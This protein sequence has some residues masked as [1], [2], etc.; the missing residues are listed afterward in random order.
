MSR[1]GRRLTDADA[2]E[3]RL[4]HALFPE[5]PVAF[6]AGLYGVSETTASYIIRGLSY[7]RAGGPVDDRGPGRRRHGTAACFNAGCRREECRQANIDQCRQY[8]ERRRKAD[9]DQDIYKK[10]VLE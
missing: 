4:V 2:R 3:L 1:Y 7:A 9:P 10:S 8:R 6:I 5:S